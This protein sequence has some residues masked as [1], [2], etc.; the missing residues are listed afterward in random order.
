MSVHTW[1]EIWCSREI[2]LFSVYLRDCLT[3]QNALVN[4]LQKDLSEAVF[5]D[6]IDYSSGVLL[7]YY[8]ADINLVYIA[9]KV[10]ISFAARITIMCVSTRRPFIMC[11]L[12]IPLTGFCF[13]PTFILSVGD[14]AV[15]CSTIKLL[16]ACNQLYNCYL[17]L[18]ASTFGNCS[19]KLFTY[20]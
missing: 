20:M 6:S 2:H 7:P 9:G 18:P 5:Q 12:Q 10:S 8:D 1:F 16:E 17:R 14:A 19:H 13:L 11:Q 3:Y 4:L 15:Y